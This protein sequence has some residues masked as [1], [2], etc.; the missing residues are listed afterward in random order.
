M[1]VF[2]FEEGYIRPNFITLEEDGV[3]GHSGLMSKSF[4]VNEDTSQL[5]EELAQPRYVF[6]ITAIYAMSLLCNQRNTTKAFC[7]LQ[8]S[9]S[10]FLPKRRFAVDTV[11]A[12]EM[13]VCKCRE[14]VAERDYFPVRWSLFCLSI[15]GS[16]RHAGYGTF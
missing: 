1:R 7:L 14:V 10:V 9:P 13:A 5:P 15:T 16:L 3:N 4:E 6:Y 11:R 8:A 2:A 12:S